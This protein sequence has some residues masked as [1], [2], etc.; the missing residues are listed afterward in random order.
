MRE[1]S[2]MFGYGFNAHSEECGVGGKVGLRKG[3]SLM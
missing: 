3:I 1:L 2:G